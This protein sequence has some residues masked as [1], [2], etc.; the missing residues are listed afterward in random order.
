MIRTRIL[1]LNTLHYL[2]FLPLVPPRLYN[3]TV[4]FMPPVYVTQLKFLSTTAQ[5]TNG[6]DSMPLIAR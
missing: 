5:K 2:F 4:L 3:N 1:W 6:V